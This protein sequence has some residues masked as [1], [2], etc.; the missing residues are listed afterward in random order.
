MDILINKE[1]MTASVLQE[2]KVLANEE[3]DAS[4]FKEYMNELSKDELMLEALRLTARKMK[5]SSYLFK[6]IE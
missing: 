6:D 3:L 4:S 2:D 5:P 1:D